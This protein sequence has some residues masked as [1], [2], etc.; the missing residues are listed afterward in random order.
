LTPL[1]DEPFAHSL[2]AFSGRPVAIEIEFDAEVAACVGARDWH[3]SQEI[4][5]RD[6]GSIVMRLAVCDDRP[7]RSWILG[8]GGAARV[9]APVSLARDIYEEFDAGRERYMPRLPFDALPPLRPAPVKMD[10]EDAQ[11]SFAARLA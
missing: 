9:V 2:G 8:F 5:T 10:L 11:L 7:L 3:R 1:P 4:R 6:N